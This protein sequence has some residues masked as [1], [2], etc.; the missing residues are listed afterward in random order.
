MRRSA[1]LSAICLSLMCMSGCAT[2]CSLSDTG[3]HRMRP[4]GG[5]RATVTDWAGC[6][7]KPWGKN[8]P[9]WQTIPLKVYFRT[10]DL[11]L[12]FIADTWLLP[13][14]LLFSAD[15]PDQGDKNTSPINKVSEV[16]PK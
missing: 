2:F 9:S 1:L 3:M 11:P 5:I 7:E 12:S 15:S 10:I 6:S 8:D 14:T 16:H 4:Y 13:F